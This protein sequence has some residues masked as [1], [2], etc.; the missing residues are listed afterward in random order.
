MTEA[1]FV[2][3]VIGALTIAW[4]IVGALVVGAFVAVDLVRK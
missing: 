4:A 2:F 3:R 1:E